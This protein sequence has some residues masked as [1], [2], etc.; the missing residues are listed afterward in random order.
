MDYYDDRYEKLFG[1]PL[2][3]FA[4]ELLSKYRHRD[5]SIGTYHYI[6]IIISSGQL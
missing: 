2:S 1:N 3:N 6:I 4:R 5:V